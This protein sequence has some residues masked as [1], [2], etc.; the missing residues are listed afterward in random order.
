[1]YDILVFFNFPYLQQITQNTFF[2]LSRL[3]SENILALFYQSF[4]IR[5]DKINLDNLENFYL[6][7]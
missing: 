1:M 3:V 6:L 5:Y 7:A 4:Y 2:Y